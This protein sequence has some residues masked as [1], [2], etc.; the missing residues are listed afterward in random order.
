MTPNKIIV[1]DTNRQLTTNIVLKFAQGISCASTDWQVRFQ[2]INR[3][4]KKGLEKTLR[5]GVDAVASLGILRGTGE[6]FRAAAAAGI[7]YYYMD[8]AYFNAGYGGENW[9]RIVKNHHTMNWIGNSNGQRYQTLFEKTNPILPWKNSTQRGDRIVIC[10]P[11]D[12]V[13]WYAGHKHNW[14]EN[15]VQQLKSLLPEKDHSRIL[16][17]PKPNEPLVDD[18]GNLLGFKQNDTTGDLNSDLES[19]QCVIAYNSMVALTATLNGIPVIGGNYSCCMPLSFRLHDLARPQVFDREPVDRRKL[20][21]WLADNQW[22][23]AEIQD[24]TAWAQLQENNRG[25]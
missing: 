7:D 17:R 13:S 14:A 6:M 9:M 1:Y 24:G 8:H 3:F 22:S 5:P 12:A 18:A 19:A 23:L 15:V 2:K 25:V 20:I 16:V 21:H 10:P 4:R 11:T